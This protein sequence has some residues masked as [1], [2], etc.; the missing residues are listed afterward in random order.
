MPGMKSIKLLVGE[1]S[2]LSTSFIAAIGA[3]Q[4][5]LDWLLRIIASIIAIGAGICSIYFAKKRAEKQSGGR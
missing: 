5:Q 1:V 3:W 4:E 2:S